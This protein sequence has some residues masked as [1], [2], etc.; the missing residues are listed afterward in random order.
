MNDEVL[1]TNDTGEPRHVVWVDLKHRRLGTVSAEEF[2]QGRIN[3]SQ[4]HDFNV[5]K[6]FTIGRVG[7][8]VEPGGK[9]R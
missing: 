1:W 3:E 9:L 8:R 4:V 5:Q 2:A 6:A 7:V